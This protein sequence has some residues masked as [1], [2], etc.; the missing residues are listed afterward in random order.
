MSR[1]AKSVVL[2]RADRCVFLERRTGRFIARSLL[3]DAL[4]FGS[5]EYSFSPLA[6]VVSAYTHISSGVATAA[7]P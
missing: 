5:I 6:E 1:K 4:H 3:Q 7:T 2:I